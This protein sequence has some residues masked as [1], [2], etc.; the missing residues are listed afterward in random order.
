MSTI[1]F[2][3]H[4]VNPH[5]FIITFKKHLFAKWPRLGKFMIVNTHGISINTERLESLALG[6]VMVPLGQ[7]L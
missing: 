6:L 2:E 5:V 1:C 4:I 7:I 3:T